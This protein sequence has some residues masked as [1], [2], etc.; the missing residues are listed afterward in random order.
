MGELVFQPGV[1]V[2]EGWL[3]LDDVQGR[4]DGLGGEL[5]QHVVKPGPLACDVTGTENRFHLQKH[6]TG[7]M[8]QKG[9]IFTT[10]FT[11]CCAAGCCVFAARGSAHR[12]AFSSARS[13]SP[14]SMLGKQLRHTHKQLLIN[15]YKIHCAKAMPRQ[16][17]AAVRAG[18]HC[19]IRY[20]K[21]NAV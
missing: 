7:R 8:G 12:C 17:L 14:S 15:Y 21:K 4:G 19:K 10:A 6:S 9:G 3:V 5:L 16:V 11:T 1:G 2:G 18:A 13:I 20:T